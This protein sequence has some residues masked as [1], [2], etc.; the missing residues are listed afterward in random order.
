MEHHPHHEQNR[1]ARRANLSQLIST[2]N[3]ND[4][5][6]HPAPV[7]G[8]ARDRHGRWERDAMD[9]H[10]RAQS[11]RDERCLCGRRSRVVLAPRRWR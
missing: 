9:A 8:A 10:R 11:L 1:F 4:H 7:R 5:P 6:S 3:Q 2:P